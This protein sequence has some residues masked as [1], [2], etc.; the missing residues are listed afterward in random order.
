MFSRSFQKHL[1][2]APPITS[3]EALAAVWA[4]SLV[5]SAPRYPGWD[6]QE[7]MMGSVSGVPQP[8]PRF[9]D[10]L[11]RLKGLSTQYLS[12][13]FIT[14]KQNQRKGVWAK[15]GRN[16]AQ[17]SRAPFPVESHRMHS[18]PPAMSCDNTCE[19]LSARETCLRL[20]ILGFFIRGESPSA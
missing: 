18:S 1:P 2:Q 7:V 16:Q 15:S 8:T 4:P 12:L 6:L 11:R 14:T 9:D 10:S 17:A 3:R 19:M 5:Q 13:W 20:E